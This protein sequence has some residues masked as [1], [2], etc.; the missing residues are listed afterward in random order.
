MEFIVT[1][2]T[3]KILSYTG[4]AH[5]SIDDSA[6]LDINDGV[7]NKMKVSQTGWF[8]V[9][10]KESGAPYGDFDPGTVYQE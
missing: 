2:A 10:E 3:G 8:S 6:V 9:Q 5:Y 1:F 4:E 7:G